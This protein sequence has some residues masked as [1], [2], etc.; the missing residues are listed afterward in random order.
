[1]PLS[2]SVALE[3]GLVISHHLYRDLNEHAA[4]VVQR[5][6]TTNSQVS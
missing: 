6:V 2:A 5:V 1:M 3:V 4:D